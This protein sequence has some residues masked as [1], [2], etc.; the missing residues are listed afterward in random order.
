MPRRRRFLLVWA[1]IGLLALAPAG[2]LLA[3]HHRQPAADPFALAAAASRGIAAALN[4]NLQRWMGRCQVLA[5]EVATLLRQLPPGP[6]GSAAEATL[7]LHLQQR[8]S[9]EADLGELTLL[10]PDG[11]TLLSTDGAR[12]GERE[13]ARNPEVAQA[14]RRPAAALVGTDGRGERGQIVVAAPVKVGTPPSLRGIMVARVRAD[15]VGRLL[16]GVTP[17]TVTAD[18]V[19]AS[20]RALRRSLPRGSIELGSESSPGRRWVDGRPVAFVPLDLARAVVVAAG[21]PS[22]PN[23]VITLWHLVGAGVLL[24]LAGVTSWRVSA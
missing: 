18:V 8:L 1:V 6:L 15:V 16:R 20:G 4:A 22:P 9:G 24:L 13:H 23:P 10:A 17:Q 12:V 14:A 19:D 7:M 11:T 21:P 5:G 2:L 3:L